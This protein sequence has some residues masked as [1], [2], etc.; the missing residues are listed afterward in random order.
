MMWFWYKN[1]TYLILFWYKLISSSIDIILGNFVNILQIV[2]T[3]TNYGQWL[4]DV[5]RVYFPRWA[6]DVVMTA[7]IR[8]LKWSQLPEKRPQERHIKLP[9]YISTLKMIVILVR[10]V[11]IFCMKIVIEKHWYS[12]KSVSNTQGSLNISVWIWRDTVGASLASSCYV[13][14]QDLRLLNQFQLMV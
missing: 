11:V 7:R 9:S 2:I 4:P 13:Y 8:M 10:A 1:E 12:R 3:E 5:I 14:V 6:V